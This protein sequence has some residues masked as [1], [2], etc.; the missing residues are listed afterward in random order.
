M[1]RNWRVRIEGEVLAQ[2]KKH[3]GLNKGRC[4]TFVDYLP[5]WDFSRIFS[6][7]GIF[8]NFLPNWDFRGFSPKL[9]FS[10]IFSI[11]SK[12]GTAKQWAGERVRSALFCGLMSLQDESQ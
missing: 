8:A 7:T 6:Q 1:S 9:G 2:P 4:N 10:R 11:D 5:T 3:L 12:R